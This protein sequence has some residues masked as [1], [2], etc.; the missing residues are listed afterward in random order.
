MGTTNR[1]HASFRQAKMLHFALLNK[2]LYRPG[3]IFNRD[4]RVNPVL[5][6]QVDCFNFE[7]LERSFDCLLNMLWST[8]QGCRT[9][10]SIT[11]T[12]VESELR[13]NY[14][15]LAERNQSFADKFLVYKGAI[16]L[17]SIK[18]RYTTLHSSM[19]KGSHLLFVFRWTVG[20]T[21]SHAA[22]PNRR[23]F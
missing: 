15:L 23:D 1:L 3:D 16:D 14:H 18:E 20:K 10:A 19:K 4:I 13:C 8:V 12:E 2:F 5:I 11:T 17:S 22:E 7:S 21:H 6:E 9:R